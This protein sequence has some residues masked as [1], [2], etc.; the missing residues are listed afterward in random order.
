MTESNQRVLAERIEQ[1]DLTAPSTR[2][3]IWRYDNAG[4]VT[5]CDAWLDDK[6]TRH[7]EYLYEEGTLLLKALIAKDMETGLIHIT[8]FTT[9][10]R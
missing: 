5:L 6:Q 7:S 8:R 1:S 4:N 10:R 3:H 2:K 9:Q